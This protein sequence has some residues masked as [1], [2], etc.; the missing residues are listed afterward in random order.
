MPG[1]ITVKGKIENGQLVLDRE[2]ASFPWDGEVEVQV[3]LE[4][5]ALSE[6]DKQRKKL[7]FEQARQD[8]QQ[9]FKGAGIE[10]REQILELIQDVKREMYEERNC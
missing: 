8:M 3:T 1:T 6:T 5:T 2:N 4:E 9:A 10:T 7:E